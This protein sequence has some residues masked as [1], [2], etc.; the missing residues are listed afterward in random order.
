VIEGEEERGSDVVAHG[1]GGGGGISIFEGFEDLAVLVACELDALRIVDATVCEE[2]A[3]LELAFLDGSCER[4]V[5]GAL[6]DGAVKGEVGVEELGEGG[7]FEADAALCHEA[8]ADA[9]HGGE[10]LVEGF[11]VAGG[12]ALGC[13]ECCERFDSLADFV[14]FDGG[15]AGEGADDGAEAGDE[16]DEAFAGESADGFADWGGGDAEFDGELF[17]VQTSAWGQRAVEKLG[18]QGLMH[19]FWQR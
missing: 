12:E 2:D 18:A 16:F 13:F 6:E 9:G 17:I 19:P 14:E 15:F 4:A 5:A 11:D 1:V 3:C 8:I 7:L 10:V